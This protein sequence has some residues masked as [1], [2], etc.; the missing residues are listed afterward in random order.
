MNKLNNIKLPDGYVCNVSILNNL[1]S[2]L[3]DW[4]DITNDFLTSYN[5]LMSN[6]KDLSGDEE[7]EQSVDTLQ[8][9]IDAAL[10]TIR[11]RISMIKDPLFYNQFPESVQEVL[12]KNLNETYDLCKCRKDF[13]E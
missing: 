10:F 13:L 3:N 12:T 4:I 8:C 9:K 7:Y 1:L 5:E 2:D 11:D 6:S